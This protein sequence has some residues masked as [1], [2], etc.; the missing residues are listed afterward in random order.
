MT[1]T[2]YLTFLITTLFTTHDVT[3]MQSLALNNQPIFILENENMESHNRQSRINSLKQEARDCI[4]KARCADLHFHIAELYLN[5]DAP[6]KEILKRAEYHLNKVKSDSEHAKQA[7][8]LRNILRGWINE[9]K[10]KTI[11]EK[12]LKNTKDVDLKTVQSK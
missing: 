7:M 5:H 10:Q 8:L 3:F 12:H 1:I 6:S 4:D 11:L 2:F 9:I